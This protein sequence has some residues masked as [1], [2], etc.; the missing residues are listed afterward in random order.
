MCFVMYV[1][2]EVKGQLSGVHSLFPPCGVLGIELRLLGLAANAY[3][4]NHLAS[5]YVNFDRNL[6]VY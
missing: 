4:L 5:P 6:Y 3:I 2:A 1:G